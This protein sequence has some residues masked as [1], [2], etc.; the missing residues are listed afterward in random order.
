MLFG[1]SWCCWWVLVVVCVAH[2][3]TNPLIAFFLSQ[4]VVTKQS[5]A[6]PFPTHELLGRIFLSTS[7]HQ[8]RSLSIILS[9]ILQKFQL[10]KRV[11]SHQNT[12][13]SG[14]NAGFTDFGPGNLRGRPTYL[15]PTTQGLL[16]D[17]EAH[18]LVGCKIRA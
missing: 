9:K 3:H 14:A 12:K 10:T 8:G 16:R 13:K 15:P 5:K 17:Y 1:G 2:E 6:I 18:L 11:P 4:V 7:Q